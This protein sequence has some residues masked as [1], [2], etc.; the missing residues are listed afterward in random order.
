[1]FEYMASLSRIRPVMPLWKLSRL[2]LVN[3]PKK[4]R[5]TRRLVATCG[6][7][8]SHLKLVTSGCA[9]RMA[10]VTEPRAVST[11]RPMGTASTGL[12]V[13]AGPSAD[14]LAPR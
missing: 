4:R 6:L 2:S 9:E 3:C 12:L 8:L 7:R 10:V 11:S 14:D 1:M 5:F 13:K